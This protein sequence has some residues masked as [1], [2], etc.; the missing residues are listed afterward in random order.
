MYSCLIDRQKAAQKLVHI[1]LD[2]CQIVRWKSNPFVFLN[3]A[4]N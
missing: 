2:Q 1:A 4:V 3:V